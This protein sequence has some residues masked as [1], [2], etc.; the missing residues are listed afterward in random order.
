MR[1]NSRLWPRLAA[2]LA[3]SAVFWA[4]TS[5]LQACPFCGVAQMSLAEQM[6]TADAAILVTWSGGEKATDKS[7]GNTVYEIKQVVKGKKPL[8]PN[9]KVTLER[10]RPGKAGD[11]FLILGT[12]A[13]TAMGVEWGSPLEVTETSFQ[14]ISQAPSPEVA[15]QKRLAYFLKFLEFS[16]PT[17][18][19]D[20][21][22]EFANAQ[23]K[24]VASIKPQLSSEQLRKWIKNPETPATRLGLYGMLIGLC[25]DESDAVMLEERILQETED[26]RL[27]IDGLMGG[28]LL[29]RGDKGLDVLDQHKLK[30]TKI[31]FSETF[32]AMQALRFMWTYGED[33][34]PQER[35]RASMRILLDRPDLADLVIADL[36]R[37]KDWSIQD[38]LLS[39]YD[40]QPYNVPSVKR[41]IVRF[42]LASTKDGA[43][44]GAAPLPEHI[45]KGQAAIKH[46]RAVDPRIVSEAEK[47]FVL[48]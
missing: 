42:M 32:A 40:K 4:S 31:P 33:R 1:L 18:A 45:T 15:P 30:N 12:D 14:Y 41:A 47:F 34:I 19:N 20:A 7:A 21:F 26:F 9:T 3:L 44:G 43:Q 46:L 17:I 24:D 28:Y 37:W 6:S 38:R 2:L 5:E 23:Y 39:I 36:A 11:L 29:I 10:F 8:E 25:G 27:G 48:P 22:A 13:G 35:L 16:D